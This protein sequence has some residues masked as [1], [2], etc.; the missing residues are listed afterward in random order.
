MIIDTCQGMSL[1]DEVE[2]PNL[3]LLSTSSANESAYSHQFSP[4]LNTG[5]NDKFTYYF[6]EFL[7]DKFDGAKFT[8]FTIINEFPKMFPRSI[9]NSNLVIKNTH[10][11][12]SLEQVHLF[13][14]IPLP[15]HKV[16]G[17]NYEFFNLDEVGE[18]EL[19]Y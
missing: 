14:Y 1:Y 2:A 17:Q 10:P 3:F 8:E 15:K 18:D 16:G 6:H 7:H 13:E 9:L 4:S 11:T 5:L 12:K 19:L